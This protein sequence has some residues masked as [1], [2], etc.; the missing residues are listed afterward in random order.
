MLFTSGKSNPPKTVIVD[1]GHGGFDGGA[2]VGDVLE[3][4]IN[5]KVA[6]YLKEIAEKNGKTEIKGVITTALIFHLVLAVMF[7]A[8]VAVCI[9]R[10]GFSI[11]PICLIVF[12][13]FMYKDEFKKQEIIERYL[14]KAIKLLEA[15]RTDNYRK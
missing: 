14:L 10:R 4:D 7:F 6:M 2:V 13:V 5:L 11:V 1:A 3:K 9:I 15:E 8:F 12:D